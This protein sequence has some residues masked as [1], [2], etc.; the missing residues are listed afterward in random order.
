MCIC[1]TFMLSLQL[2]PHSPSAGGML[3]PVGA[4]S[5]LAWQLQLLPCMAA[6]EEADSIGAEFIS[7]VA[8]AAGLVASL[9]RAGSTLGTP[10]CNG[11]GRDQHPSCLAVA[12]TAVVFCPAL[13]RLHPYWSRMAMPCLACLA[14]ATCCAGSG[15]PSV[16]AALQTP[17]PDLSHCAVCRSSGRRWLPGPAP[18]CSPVQRRS[19]LTISTNS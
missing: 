2:T 7:W 16:L 17:L 19:R 13:C 9:K 11:C 4:S 6:V 5:I 18:S 14:E 1:S 15:T 12:C 3:R 8:E 10:S